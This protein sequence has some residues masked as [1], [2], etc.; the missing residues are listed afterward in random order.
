M[1]ILI[2]LQSNMF[3]MPQWHVYKSLVLLN[4]IEPPF[5]VSNILYKFLNHVNKEEIEVAKDMEQ[6]ELW[7]KQ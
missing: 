3:T 6:L 4:I 1:G 2:R 7:F 5:C